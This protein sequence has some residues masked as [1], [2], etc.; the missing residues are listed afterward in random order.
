MSTTK[1]YID[2]ME[3]ICGEV[4]DVYELNDGSSIAVFPETAEV[5]S[6]SNVDAA[7]NKLYRM[8]F[9]F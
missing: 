4:V 7:F 9:R 3:N 2:S 5:I 8:G 1:E 6:F